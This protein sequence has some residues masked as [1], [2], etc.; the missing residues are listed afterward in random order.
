LNSRPARRV[1]PATG[2]QLFGFHDASP[3][4]AAHGRLLALQVERIDAP[5]GPGDVAGVGTIDA[6]SGRFTQHD[7]TTGWNFP[8]GARQLWLQDRRRYAYNCP[9]RGQPRT[10]IRSED[11]RLLHELPWGVAAVSPTRDEIYSIDFG[12]VHRLGGYGHAGSRPWENDD[13]L[14]QA[15]GIVGID[16]ASGR[17]RTVASLAGCRRAAGWAADR[18]LQSVPADYVTHVDPSPDGRWLAV[19]HRMWVADGGLVTSLCIAD[20]DRPDSVRCLAQGSLSHFAWRTERSLIIWGRRQP[21]A[22]RFRSCVPRGQGVFAA[23]ARAAKAALR[24]WIRHQAASFLVVTV[25][26]DP[27][28][29]WFARALPEDGHPSFCPQQR[30]WLLADTYP[31]PAGERDLFLLDTRTGRRHLL[32]VFRQPSLPV[33]RTRALRSMEGIEADVLRMIGPDRYAFTQSGLH[34]D[35]HP[36]WRNDGRQVAFDSLHTGRRRIHVID[37]TDLVTQATTDGP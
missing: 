37:T 25:D 22:A 30:R 11:G 33:D 2:H 16:I 9:D 10:R 35:L 36:R 1:G 21:L 27:P 31:C 20:V 13:S 5:P 7:D 4:D 6:T 3:W 15:G 28:Q 23:A 24:P 17:S 29:P 34:C 14:R 19:L 26:G 8:Q 18:M 32:G 12:R